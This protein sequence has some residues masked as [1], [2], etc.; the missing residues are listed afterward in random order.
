MLMADVLHLFLTVF[1]KAMIDGS[2]PM[3]F[4]EVPIKTRN[5]VRNF[6]GSVNLVGEG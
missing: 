6:T 4:E 2:R 1:P 3:D 5:Q